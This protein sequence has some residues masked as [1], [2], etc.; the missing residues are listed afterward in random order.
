MSQGLSFLTC[1]LGRIILLFF[2]KAVRVEWHKRGKVPSVV[3]GRLSINYNYGI[4]LLQ[5]ELWFN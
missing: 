2:H 5:S 3:S 1:K 4:V